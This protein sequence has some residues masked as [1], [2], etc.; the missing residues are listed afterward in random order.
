MLSVSA[1]SSAGIPT[2]DP[3]DEAAAIVGRGLGPKGDPLLRSETACVALSLRGNRPLSARIREAGRFD[4]L[5]VTEQRAAL[6]PVSQCAPAAL[7]RAVV[8]TFIVLSD[9]EWPLSALARSQYECLGRDPT[10][11]AKL[12][13]TRAAT[14]GHR[15]TRDE[16][17]ASATA[18]YQSATD[19]VTNGPLSR[20]L[21]ITARQAACLALQVSGSRSLIAEASGIMFGQSRSK[22]SASL[23]RVISQCKAAAP[24]VELRR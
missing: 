8:H 10:M 22:K 4:R 7:G 14:R 11:P 6:R 21:R 9:H 12:V 3:G 19:Y 23:R 15:L 1:A 18:L 17:A 13:A 16:M 2:A 20:S 5:G 24:A